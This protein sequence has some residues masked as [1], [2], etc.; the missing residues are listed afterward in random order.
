MFG[1]NITGQIQSEMP[2]LTRYHRSISVEPKAQIE[3]KT[4]PTSFH[5]EFDSGKWVDDNRA[6]NPVWGT[7]S[8]QGRRVFVAG[9]PWVPN[10]KNLLEDQF[11]NV[12]EGYEMQ[13]PFPRT[14]NNMHHANT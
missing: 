10:Q 2:V 11:G 6:F 5:R 7:G 8:L 4:S 14:W 3:K 1:S 12:F 9:L 13:I